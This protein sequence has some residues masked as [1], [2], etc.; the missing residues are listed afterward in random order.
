M[1]NDEWTLKSDDWHKGWR[2]GQ[3][4][5][6]VLKKNTPDFIDGYKYAIEH[7]KGSCYSV[8]ATT[9]KDKAVKLDEP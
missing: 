8:G 2:Y 3:G 9:G 7:P 6:F 4:D 5:V 1:T